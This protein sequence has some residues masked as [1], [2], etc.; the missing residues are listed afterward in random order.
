MFEEV[1]TV[2]VGGGTKVKCFAL[3]MGGGYCEVGGG[4][5]PKAG[6]FLGG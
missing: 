3:L 4:V 2:P 6:W 5:G 1:E